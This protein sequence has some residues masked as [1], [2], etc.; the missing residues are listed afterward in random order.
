MRLFNL[1]RHRR[2]RCRCRCRNRYRYPHDCILRVLDL[3]L[4]A[5]VH[6]AGRVNV[7]C[8]K[9]FVNPIINRIT[10]VQNMFL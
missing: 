9:A 10:F 3:I 1:S 2:N 4:N 7:L 6:E 5:D 8:S